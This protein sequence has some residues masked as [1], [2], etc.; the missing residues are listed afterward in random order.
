MAW[1][2][3]NSSSPAQ[4][5]NQP[6]DGVQPTVTPAPAA[7]PRPG[8]GQNTGISGATHKVAY[9]AAPAPT[10]TFTPTWP[11]RRTPRPGPIRY[12]HAT[13]PGDTPSMTAPP[14]V[15]TATVPVL[16]GSTLAGPPSPDDPAYHK[17]DGTPGLVY[18][19]PHA[20]YEGPH[21]ASGGVPGYLPEEEPVGDDEPVANE[22]LGIFDDM[23]TSEVPDD[24]EPADQPAEPNEP[25]AETPISGAVVAI[26]AAW[27]QPIASAQAPGNAVAERK[28][29]SFGLRIKGRLRP[30][31]LQ[32]PSNI[33]RVAVRDLPPD[34]QMSFIRDRVI[35]VLAV[36]ILPYIFVR[37]WPLSVTLMII[38]F[39]LDV[40]RRQR[41]AI[42][43]V[44]GGAHP[45]ARRATSKQLRRLRRAGFYTLDAR[46]IPGSREFI[47]HLVIGPTG[48][49]AID[50][51]KWNP[52][53]PIR[54]WNNKKLYHGPE[55][56]KPRLEHAV[57]EAAQAS[58]LLS[59]TLG[60]EVRVRPALAIYGPKIPW[61][62][63]TIRGVDVFTGSSL[64]KYLRG[65]WRRRDDQ[66][67]PLTS[68][69]VRE[70]YET[71][72]QVLP[73]VATEHEP[74]G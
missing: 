13:P 62:I 33:P 2:R 34:V 44:N 65:R 50:S 56:Q 5:G 63:A 30:G 32:E 57:W 16:S 46:P 24:E 39:V 6:H 49:F 41:T 4:P 61:D 45:G 20:G 1:P 12:A 42:L 64:G 51:E 3:K 52:K 8:T 26:G 9:E 11:R 48:V 15:P 37:S 21:I 54:T 71:A 23:A 31:G 19:A 53:M 35:I 66:P 7:E 74:V 28:P 55:S 59:S 10:P 36:G 67:V 68:E 40:I 38:A 18:E 22:G 58:E 70:L 17:Y 25:A 29:G 43:Y 72:T 47:D 60:Y 14:T 73:D 69:Q 27:N